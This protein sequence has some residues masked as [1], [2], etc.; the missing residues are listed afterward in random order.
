MPAWQVAAGSPHLSTGLSAESEF[1]CEQ[2]VSEGRPT[3]SLPWGW[4]G[5][6]ESTVKTWETNPHTPDLTRLLAPSWTCVL[7]LLALPI[8]LK[9]QGIKVLTI[10]MSSTSTQNL[11]V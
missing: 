2:V 10:Y 11:L 1:T 6:A 9:P 8:S 3:A 7:L 5:L 4:T